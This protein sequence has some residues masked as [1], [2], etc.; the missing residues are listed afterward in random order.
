M[1]ARIYLTVL[2]DEQ[3]SSR[4]LEGLEHAKGFLRSQLAS[5]VE[6][7]YVPELE[8]RLDKSADYARRIDELLDQLKD[9]SVTGDETDT[10]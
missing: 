1:I 5:R 7:R 6:L 4:A 2:G 9:R 8:F 10:E 3:V